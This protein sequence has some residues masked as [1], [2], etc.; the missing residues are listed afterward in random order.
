MNHV[1]LESLLAE[2][3]RLPRAT[4]VLRESGLRVLLL[5]LGPGE[6]IPEHQTRGAITVQ[7]LRGRA[8]FSYDGEQV[9]LR[10]HWMI[11][12]GPAAPHSVKA[13][14]HTLL[15]VTISEPNG[16]KS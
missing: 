15:L 8:V 1:D 2:A 16:E 10:P 13:D 7:C 14:E 3:G 5:S 12:L 4:T 6:Q 9:N 11:S